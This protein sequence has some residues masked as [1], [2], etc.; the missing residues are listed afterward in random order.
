ML[1]LSQNLNKG[2]KLPW[3]HNLPQQAEQKEVKKTVN[4]TPEGLVNNT[5][6]TRN[7]RAPLKA[8]NCNMAV[9]FAS[10]CSDSAMNGLQEE[11]YD[12][13]DKTFYTIHVFNIFPSHL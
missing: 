5:N 3:L 9:C 11:N 6:L 2:T 10:F 13:V 4:R 12:E 8:V 1:E 7:N